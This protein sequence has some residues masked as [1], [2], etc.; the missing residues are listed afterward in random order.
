MELRRKGWMKKMKM[1]RLLW[2][3]TRLGRGE[4]RCKNKR[5]GSGGTERGAEQ[6]LCAWTDSCVSQLGVGSR[7][8]SDPT[9]WQEGGPF[10]CD[11]GRHRDTEILRPVGQAVFACAPLANNKKVDVLRD[12]AS[13]A[14]TLCYFGTLPLCSARLAPSQ[15]SNRV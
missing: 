4:L 5:K 12:F 8:R 1:A 13:R 3:C 9:L 10:R 11:V 6:A 14:V 7:M 15:G 2:S